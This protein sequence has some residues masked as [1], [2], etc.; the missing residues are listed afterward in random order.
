MEEIIKFPEI[1]LKWSKLYDFNDIEKNIKNSGVNVP[2]V[3]G[4]YK[5]IDEKGEILHIGKASNLRNRIKQAFVKGNSPHS[6][7]KR[8]LDNG[9]DL[10]KLKIQWAVTDYPSSVEEYLHKKYKEKF[11]KLPK[12]TKVT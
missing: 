2:A 9:I 10:K 4:V 6:T 1:K 8:M 5:V 11:G 7:R 12:F 3:P